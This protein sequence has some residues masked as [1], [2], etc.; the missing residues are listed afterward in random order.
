MVDNK[1][2]YHVFT[3]FQCYAIHGKNQIF[4]MCIVPHSIHSQ[5]SFNLRAKR[6]G[7]SS[8]ILVVPQILSIQNWQF[9]LR[10]YLFPC[11]SCITYLV[12]MLLQLCMALIGESQEFHAKIAHRKCT[13]GLALCSAVAGRLVPVPGALFE[14]CRAGSASMSLA[15][16]QFLQLIVN[17]ICCV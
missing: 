7:S 2:S 5:D 4:V 14:E 6:S 3:S 13:E 11:F 1:C 17:L 10:K 16:T 9:T 15:F 8:V 12:K